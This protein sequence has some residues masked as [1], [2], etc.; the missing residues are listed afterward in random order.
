MNVQNKSNTFSLAISAP[1]LWALLF[2]SFFVYPLGVFPHA[3]TISESVFFNLGYSISFPGSI[4]LGLAALPILMFFS[5][6]LN[7]L[8]SLAVITFAIM[9]VV[10]MPKDLEYVDE[11]LI[12]TSY[13]TIPIA[14]AILFKSGRISLPKIAPWASGLWLLQILL[15]CISLYSQTEPVGTTG[16]INWMAALLLMLSPWVI[17]YTHNL[18][19]N[20]VSNRALSYLLAGLITSLPTLIIL[21][22][23][24]SRAAWL[25]LGLTPLFLCIVRL[26][27]TLYKFLFT[28]VLISA[29]VGS[30]IAAYVW[31]P[32]SLLKVGN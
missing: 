19:K 12:L 26:H 25:A 18:I 14:A 11:F 10:N 15:G 3:L 6:R 4:I 16:N 13:I 23:C 5:W 28:T 27:R 22:H 29:I 30:L 21:Y 17:W 20:W 31:F 9:L 32:V 2:L 1:F 8:L 24:Q 7:R